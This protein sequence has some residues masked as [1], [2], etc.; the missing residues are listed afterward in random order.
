MNKR[1]WIKTLPCYVSNCAN[2]DIDPAHIRTAQNS[3]MGMKP[4]DE[5][6]I[7]LCRHHHRDVQHQHGY[8]DLVKL[9]GLNLNRFDAKQHLLMACEVYD[10][11]FDVEGKNAIL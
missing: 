4:S 3:G 11:R 6:L 9:C 10:K 7:P 1:Q 5:W 2:R 8:T